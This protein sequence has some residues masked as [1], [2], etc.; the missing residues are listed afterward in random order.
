VVVASRSETFCIAAS[1]ALMAG[2]PVVSSDASALPE[3]VEHEKTGLLF[4]SGNVESLEQTLTQLL[5]NADL[6]QRL[7]KQARITSLNRYAPSVVAENMLQFYA[8][9]IKSEEF[10]KRTKRN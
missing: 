2:C 9:V 3:V 5:E 10:S 6:A 1:E 8:E 7:G 4:R